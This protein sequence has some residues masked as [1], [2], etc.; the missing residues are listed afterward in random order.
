[1]TQCDPTESPG[2]AAAQPSENSDAT[3][4]A[5]GPESVRRIL[6]DLAALRQQAA[7]YLAARQDQVRLVVRNALIGAVLGVMALAI[8][9][10]VLAAAAV[11]IVVG[12]ALGLG[13]ALGDRLWLGALLT[14]LAVLGL[15]TLAGYLAIHQLQQSSRRNTLRRYA[16]LHQRQSKPVPAAA[17]GAAAGARGT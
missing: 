12:I 16:E 11:L 14:G 6:A 1:M 15:T 8:L 13:E 10:A 4:P 2:A 9:A 3:S 5:T 17:P 7:L